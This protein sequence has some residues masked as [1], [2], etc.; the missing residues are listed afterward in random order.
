MPLASLLLLSG[1]L[2]GSL[3][4]IEAAPASYNQ[5]QNGDVNVDTKWDNFVIL[6]LDSIDKSW[7]NKLTSEVATDLGSLA[8]I[9]RSN[10]IKHEAPEKPS[11][12]MVHETE[13]REEGR[14]PYHVEIVRIQKDDV[15]AAV[16]EDEVTGT[17][18]ESP[19]AQ[20]DG[21]EIS[22]GV[23]ASKTGP[24]NQKSRELIDGPRSKKVRVGSMVDDLAQ[25]DDLAA[26]EE[27][28]EAARPGISLKKQ[29]STKEEEEPSGLSDERNELSNKRDE[30]VLLGDGVENCGPGRYRDK[31]GTCQEDKDFY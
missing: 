12:A 19:K 7:L 21:P 26:K 29:L 22:V 23:K 25:A 17:A 9:G 1:V 13:E 30:L 18:K 27:A 2:S 28:T 11:E 20:K 5:R 31:S 8:L 3:A 4:G 6:V 16:T 10:V 24:R 14:E 15:T